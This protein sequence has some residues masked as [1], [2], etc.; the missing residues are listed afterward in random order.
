MNSLV[1]AFDVAQA[2]S[3]VAYMK[4]TSIMQGKGDS[5]FGPLDHATRAEAV[6]VLLNM[7]SLVS[8]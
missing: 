1:Q 6:T 3:S 5:H 8:E 2:S 7:L 4:Q